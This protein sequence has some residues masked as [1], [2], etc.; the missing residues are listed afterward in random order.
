MN[1]P[2]TSKDLKEEA[3]MFYVSYKRHATAVAL[4]WGIFTCGFAVINVIV[5]IQ[6]QWIGYIN[7]YS[8]KSGYMGLY[9]RCTLT[10]DGLDL[11]CTGMFNDFSSISNTAFRA[12]TFFVGVSCL[13]IF[14]CCILF[15]LFLFLRNHSI[16]YLTCGI[17]QFVS[18]TFMFLGCIIYPAGWS[19]SNVKDICGDSDQYVISNCKVGWAYILAMVGI[20]DALFIAILAFVLAAR[21]ED[22]TANRFSQVNNANN[23]NGY[24]DENVTSKSSMFI[25]PGFVASDNDRMSQYS[26][27]T[28]RSRKSDFAL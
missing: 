11:H 14:I 22:W 26:Q 10:S 5:F 15:A 12:S 16:V 9:E 7:Q 1:Q 27:S 20:F 17:M 6:P 18:A 3:H 21:Q 28:R 24:I 25:Q 13:I 23:T 19:D 8:D 2:I 4:M